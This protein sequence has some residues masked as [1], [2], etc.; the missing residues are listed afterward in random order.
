MA[1]DSDLEKTEA[2][3]PQRL[4]KAREEGQVARSR[5]LNTCLILLCGVS[6][7]WAMGGWLYERL[8]YVMR[9]TMHFDWGPKSSV[10]TLAPGMLDAFLH[11]LIGLLPLFLLLAVVAIAASVA[12]GGLVFSGKALQPNFGRMNI[13]KGLGR[14]VSAATWVELLKTL[15]KAAVIGGVGVLTIRHYLPEMLALSHLSLPRSLAAGMEIVIICCA[16]II[17]SLLI[18]ALI[19]V[20]WQLFSHAKKL[21]MSKEEVKRE[22]KENE[23]DPHI[24]GRIRQQQR[25]MA[26]RRMM[27]QV[28][29][30][31]VVVTNPTHYAV[32][33]K[34]EESGDTAPVV[35]A[36][37][38][39]EIA[40][41]IREVAAEHRVTLF[42]QPALARA[43]YTHVELEHPIPDTLFTAVAQVLAWVYQLRQFRQGEVAEP[44]VKPV[45]L[46]VP[47]ELD[48]YT[49]KMAPDRAG[50]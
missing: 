46:P 5:E 23:G 4:E 20:P 22:F 14:M 41:K 17:A 10:E 47:P 32:A 15:A 28:P 9:T 2:A 31:D 25:E 43:L 29:T 42:E 3:S 34:Y 50:A 36:K 6:G 27:S 13:F 35:V 8:S 38:T 12:L 39:G 18:V 49:H 21:R 11:V 7:L 45:N 24:K 48:P 30:A 26:R 16:T 40:R 44:P 19:D 37:G 33:L 1:E